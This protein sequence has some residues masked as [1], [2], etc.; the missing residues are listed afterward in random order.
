MF[1]YLISSL[2]SCNCLLMINV[3][4]V[5]PHEIPVIVLE[6]CNLRPGTLQCM[7]WK[8]RRCSPALLLKSSLC[9]VS[10]VVLQL[11]SGCSSYVVVCPSCVFVV[12]VLWCRCVGG[13]VNFA[14]EDCFRIV[15]VLVVLWLY[16]SVAV[17]L[18]CWHHWVNRRLASSSRGFVA[19]ICDL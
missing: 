11:T 13:I 2:I 10:A 9:C 18:V 19:W 4:V 3:P 15:C 7:T 14:I 5:D 8:N 17:V 16:C 1:W 6:L 12:L